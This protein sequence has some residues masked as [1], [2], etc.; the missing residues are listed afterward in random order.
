MEALRFCSSFK[1]LRWPKRFKEAINYQNER[2]RSKQF[3]SEYDAGYYPYILELF[4][5]LVP[6]TSWDLC[7]EDHYSSVCCYYS[8]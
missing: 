8:I 6:P 2:R 3:L 5:H 4:S 1:K 7:E